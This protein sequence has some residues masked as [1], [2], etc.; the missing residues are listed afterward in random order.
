MA[1]AGA[2]QTVFS[3]LDRQPVQKAT[4]DFQPEEFRG[5]IQFE[6][7]SL[8]YPARPNDTAIEVDCQRLT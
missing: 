5:D 1:S 8:K 4:G 3:Y 2:S 7:V 6:D